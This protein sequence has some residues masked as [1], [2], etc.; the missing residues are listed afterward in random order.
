MVRDG[1]ENGGKWANAERYCS[2]GLL[3]RCSRMRPMRAAGG[4]RNASGESRTW[5]G[6]ARTPL[7]AVRR[8][9]TRAC[10]PRREGGTPTHP[11]TGRATRCLASVGEGGYH[12]SK[13]LRSVTVYITV[14]LAAPFSTCL[15]QDSGTTGSV[16]CVRVLYFGDVKPSVSLRHPAHPATFRPFELQFVGAAALPDGDCLRTSRAGRCPR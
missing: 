13:P 8:R 14:Q 5:S 4:R 11:K 10:C 12:G 3:R 1:D 2:T 16:C 6:R 9:A 15:A 7:R